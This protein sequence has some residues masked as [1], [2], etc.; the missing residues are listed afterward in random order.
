M[1]QNTGANKGCERAKAVHEYALWV[2][3][4]PSAADIARSLGWAVMPDAV[5]QRAAAIVNNMTCTGRSASTNLFF[6]YAT[7][8]MK[9]ACDEAYCC[10]DN[11]TRSAAEALP[12]PEWAVPVSIRGSGSSMQGGLQEALA[13][14]FALEVLASSR[15]C[16]L[17]VSL[18]QSR[19]PAQM[20]SV[21]RLAAAGECAGDSLPGPRPISPSAPNSSRPEPS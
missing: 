5:G 9:P 1:L 18:Q 13:N 8:L 3:R 14:D 4:D 2:L 11:V 10:R 21:C 19:V 12:A 15:P 17:G 16:R 20:T 6:Y 7:V